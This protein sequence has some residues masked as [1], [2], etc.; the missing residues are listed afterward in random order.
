MIYI[1]NYKKILNL[2]AIVGAVFFLS[3]MY[4]H[5][6]VYTA[7][8]RASVDSLGI[9][10]DGISAYPAVSENGRYITFE[11][12]ATNLVAGDT[13]GTQDI[14]LHDTQTGTTTRVSV[15]SVG[16]ES[17]GG[18]IRPDISEDGRYI[19]FNSGATNLVVGDINGADDIFLHDTQTG[20]TTRVSVDSVGAEA[21]DSH[22]DA[23]ISDD[24]RYVAF[25]SDSTNLVAGDTNGSPDVFLHDTQTG[26]TTRVSVDSVG[27]EG[28]GTSTDPDLSSDGRYV[29]FK[30]SAT[31]LV[32]GDINGV[33][34][35]ILHDTQTGT[36]TRVSVDSVGAEG[37]GS[38]DAG[39]I[40]ENGRYIT[41]ESD[42]TNLVAGDTNGTQDIFLHDT[43]TGTTTRVSVD[44]EGN[45]SDGNEY[46]AF[47]SGD[48]NRIVY[49]SSS[50][51]LVVGDT[52]GVFD[53]FLYNVT[54]GATQRISINELGVAGNAN[55]FFP[56][57]T[58][59]FEYIFF[60]SDAA[61]L[62][63]NDTNGVR[64]ILVSQ[65]L[66]PYELVEVTPI[67][68]EATGDTAV[69]YY[70]VSG[71]GE[72]A[73]LVDMCGG[74]S[75]AVIDH[76]EGTFTITGLEVGQTYECDFAIQNLAG[77]P[78]LTVGPFTIIE[79]SV[80]RSSVVFGCKDADAK[81]YERFSR[82]KQSLCEY[83]STLDLTSAA[84]INDK[85]VTT[86]LVTNISLLSNKLTR[87]GARGDAVKQLQTALNTHGHSLGTDGIFGPNTLK[88]VKTFQL[89]NGLVVDGV[90]GK[91]TL[92]KL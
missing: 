35:I 80:S 63:D 59:D 75:N 10:G 8:F 57:V 76:N 1:K 33:N 44:S 66:E 71:R 56:V 49:T 58:D 45:E 2:L 50:T 77:S 55:S 13:N 29:I 87:Q 11:S 69:Y 36:T 83:E 26:I 46:H 73:Y 42:A 89:A 37:N 43:Q 27:A 74:D 84:P 62:L 4:A 32:A 86:T 14:F 30:S 47:M 51:N 23:V 18:S 60:H 6:E 79:R 7:E 34:D 91:N 39:V 24:G 82:H 65:I 38:S 15:D 3:I 21:D 28:N 72:Y 54:T 9:E 64:D 61:N 41:F 48:G 85:V 20:I 22:Y 81:N 19:V 25:E 90:V 12:D 78:S 17:N 70:S 68:S 40:S 88:A 67:P 92:G 52:N 5:A 16:T 53:N 31:N